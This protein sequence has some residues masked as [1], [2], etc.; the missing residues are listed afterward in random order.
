MPTVY[1][2][3]RFPISMTVCIFQYQVSHTPMVLWLFATASVFQVSTV[4]APQRFLSCLSSYLFSE[5]HIVPQLCIQI[6]QSR[7][8]SRK[9]LDGW[10]ASRRLGK[11]IRGLSRF[12]S[13][14]HPAS[15]FRLKPNGLERLN[16]AYHQHSTSPPHSSRL[17]FVWYSQWFE[18]SFQ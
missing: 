3:Q 10:K 9:A 12:L 15:G 16:K 2:S 11:R 8:R 5:W 13:N 18:F 7:T 14:H 1:S 17:P 6:K 4:Y